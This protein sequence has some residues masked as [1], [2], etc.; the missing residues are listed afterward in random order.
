MVGVQS[1]EIELLYLGTIYSMGT[2]AAIAA[3]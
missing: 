2:D 1:K 3:L